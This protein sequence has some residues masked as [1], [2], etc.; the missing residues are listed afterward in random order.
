MPS[1]ATLMQEEIKKNPSKYPFSEITFCNIGNPQEF[2]QKPITF[3]RKVL[4]FLLNPDLI[5]LKGTCPDAAKRAESYLNDIISA[6]SYTH[7][8]GIPL[9]RRSIAKFLVKEDQ[10][11][12]PSID[13]I[14]LTEGASQGVHLLLSSLITSN[15][16]AIMIPIPQYP[17]YSA[18]ISLY[19][20]YA[21][22][23]YLT[24]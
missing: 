22:P 21:A 8:L 6:G 14:Y 24:E 9:V 15:Q 1:T 2:R 4:A 7:S 13:N 10:I 5:G 11:P 12:E 18:A 3:N 16:D 17:L 23:Y 19:G 20:G